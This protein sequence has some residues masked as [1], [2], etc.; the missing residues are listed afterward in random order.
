[1]IV[2]C[3][4]FVLITFFQAFLVSPCFEDNKTDQ[5]ASLIIQILSLI[6]L[7]NAG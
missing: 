6:L 1:M 2:F 4:N 5:E 7:L 3:Q